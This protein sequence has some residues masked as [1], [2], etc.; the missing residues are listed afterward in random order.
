M[1]R[2][3]DRKKQKKRLREK[4]KDMRQRQ[5]L[6]SL[7]PSLYPDIMVNADCEDPVFRQAVIDVV[8]RYS[9]T[10]D[11]HCP[12]ETRE[13]YLTIAKIGWKAWYLK[14]QDTAFQSHPDRRTA[15]LALHKAT[16]PHLLHFG[17]WIFQQLPAQYTERFSPA[18]FFRVDQVHTA[19]IVSF[20]L[21]ESV[22]DKGQRL[23]IPPWKPTIQMQGVN[24]EVGLYPHALD[25]LCSRL[26]PQGALTYSKCID[27]FYRFSQNMLQ[28]APV[29]LADGQ[30][31]ARVAFSPPLGT[32]FYE[33]YA[34]QVRGLL[35]LPE[36][37]DFGR[38][39]PWSIVVG[40]LPLHIQ[41]RYARAK[42]FLLPGFAKTPEHTLFRSTKTTGPERAM[43]MSMTDENCRTSDLTGD[44]LA[45][46]R[47]YH[48]N[49]VPQVF[50]RDSDDDSPAPAADA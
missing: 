15:K 18:C 40:Y 49:G 26:V 45:A 23:Y 6:A 16:L 48:D 29:T 47:W 1:A 43:L 32:V 38:D 9:H 3:E 42:T 27:V 44:T 37:Y 46:I 8:D 30:Q 36:T 25:R 34:A 31:A 14:M 35:E 41:G 11:A 50:R 13:H 33:A 12:P 10:D 22:E 5:H 28:F 21:I 39:G 19:L 24:W 2:K 4:K 20:T 7:Q 17:T